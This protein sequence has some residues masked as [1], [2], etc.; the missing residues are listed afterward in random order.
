MRGQGQLVAIAGESGAGKTAVV[1][2]FVAERCGNA[3][4]LSAMCDPLDTPRPLGPIRDVAD[5]LT[6]GS[7]RMLVDAEHAYDIFE[8][9]LDDLSA[10]P[11]ILVIDDLHWA[12]QG[13]INFLRFTLRRIH[14]RPLLAIGMAREEEVGISHPLRILLSDIARSGSAQ[15]VAL[16]P[17]TLDGVTELAGERSV[18]AAWLHRVTGGNAF[19]VTEMLDHEDDDLP[20]T[21]RDAVLGRTVGLDD[22]S[23]DLLNLLSCSPE[24]I[25][26]YLLAGLGVTIAPLRCLHEAH[27]IQRTTRGVAFRHDLCR[28][29]IASVIP[30]GAEPAL[31]ERMMAAYEQAGRTDPAVITHH[32]LGAGDQR[33]IRQAAM[34]AGKTSSRSGAH[35]QAAQF[36]S[37]AMESGGPLPPAAE[38]ELLELLAAEHYLTDQLGDA[39]DSCQRAL[40]VRM[41][42]G[43]KVEL[44]ADHHALSLYDW[45]NADGR[46]ADVHAA[47]AVSVVDGDTSLL[48]RSGLAALGHAIAMQ[49]YL[50]MQSSNLPQADALLARAKEIASAAHDPALTVRIEIIA[51]LCAVANDAETGRDSVLSIMR[52]APMHLD[53]IYSSGYSNLTYLDV[54]QRRLAD[55]AELLNISLPMTWERDLPVCRVWQ[56][57][58]RGRLSLLSG[59]WDDA[60]ADVSTVLDMQTAP[61]TRIWPHLVHGLITMRRGGVDQLTQAWSLALSN[62]EPVRVMPVATAL[63]ERAWLKGDGDVDISGYRQLLDTTVASGLEWARGELAMW[64]RRLEPSVDADGVAAPYRLYLDGDIEAAA[65]EFERV[66]TVYE[67]AV[68]LTETGID[69][70]ARR[71]LDMLDRM[72]ADAVAD[73]LRLDLRAAGMKGVPTRRNSTTLR[74]PAGLTRRQLE[75]LQRL[76]DGMTNS[77]LAAK[78]YLSAKTV[79]H[80]VSA[81]LNKLDVANRREAVRRGRELGII[82]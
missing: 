6:D 2:Q 74:N 11:T 1:E 36:Y 35:R 57:G 9:V 67:A 5:A 31:H 7:R 33:R 15:L 20:A 53:D 82:A 59:D 38:A 78:L 3:R 56:L 13:T 30:P 76:D 32:A 60:L 65:A 25:P 72:G 49:A 26:D 47:Q 37:I 54:E 8:A 69:D 62:G 40:Q 55:A 71:G 61:L 66:G 70:C 64:L 79:D 42:M 77:E 41:A 22:S 63:V 34:E 51:G 44:S 12:D 16:P 17:L 81:I 50:A 73:K 52:S 39:I 45:Y 68:A 80:H 10:E 75:V 28:L 58:V 46:G 4:V 29:A 23:W 48:D 27:L 21:V 18:D 14:R 43:A 24:A 19:F